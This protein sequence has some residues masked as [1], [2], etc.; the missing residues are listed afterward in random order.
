MYLFSFQALLTG[1]SAGG[2]ATLIHCDDFR[3]LLPME[4]KVKCL[5]DGGFFLDM[6]VLFPNHYSPIVFLFFFFFK[7]F[8]LSRGFFLHANLIR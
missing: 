1:C 2:L 5:V 3:A 6:Y 4:I 8:F 7:T